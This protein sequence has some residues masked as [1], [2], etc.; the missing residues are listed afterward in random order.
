MLSIWNFVALCAIFAALGAHGTH[1]VLVAP[2]GY[3]AYQSVLRIALADAVS[4]GYLPI[5]MHSQI[6]ITTLWESETNP[7]E[8]L[9]LARSLCPQA[10]LAIIASSNPT[11]AY[12]FG[13]ANV[14]LFC[15]LSARI[16]RVRKFVHLCSFGCFGAVSGGRNLKHDA[17]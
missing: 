7:L 4:K 5:E 10:R 15:I 1:V 8:D 11:I 14:C 9:D 2:R 6:N 16:S 17:V 13:S 12:T 3:D